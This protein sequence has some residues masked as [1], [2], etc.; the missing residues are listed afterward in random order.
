MQAQQSGRFI[1]CD[2]SMC[3]VDADR[4]GVDS[5]HRGNL[6]G[7]CSSV[8][9]MR[10]LFAVTL[11]CSVAA[12]AQAPQAPQAPQGRPR[13][14]AR[15]SMP[16]TAGAAAVEEKPGA[17]R[18]QVVSSTGEPLRKAEVSLRPSGGRGA[19]GGDP[20]M[21]PPG[22]GG[23]GSVQTTDASG[24]FAFEAVQP[25]TYTLSAQR[26]GFVRADYSRGASGRAPT[27]VEVTSGGAT[28]GI[29]IRMTPQAVLAGKVT[30]EDGDPIMH[31]SVQ[32]IRDRWVA[33][34]RTQMPMNSSNTDDRGEY[35][36]AGL[37]PG[38]YYVQVTSNRMGMQMPGQ[39][40]PQGVVGD[41]NYT[42]LLYPGVPEFSQAQP[43][44]LAPGQEM[45]GVDFRMRKSTTWR[46]RGQVLDDS[47]KPI[48]SGGVMA[49][50][51]DGGMSGP[52]AMGMA[53]G[54]EG[55]FEIAGLAPGTYTLMVSTSGRDELRMAG[56]QS[57]TVGNRDLEGV[58]LQMQRGFEISGLVRIDGTSPP[59]ASGSAR[60]MLEPMETGIMMGGG[61]SRE[62]N[63]QVKPDGAWALG[64]VSAGR[65]RITPTSLPEGTYLKAVMVGG[66]DITGG[67]QISAAAMGI[68]LVL[69]MKAPDVTGTVMNADKLPVTSGTVFMI[70]DTARRDRPSAYKSASLGEGG[71]FT[72]R[73]LAPGQYTIFA[74]PEVEDG[75]WYDPDFVRTLEG[76]GVAVK[77]AEGQS[78]T[79]QVPLS[80]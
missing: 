37:V 17:I 78:E 13:Q 64:N 57:V 35:R 40:R 8:L 34:R 51:V 4:L 61:G 65:Y 11:M 53:R 72:F 18:G 71:T 3:L 16:S 20:R 6:E 79:V 47:G 66:Q 9:S 22:M 77:L 60:V 29:A 75:S 15:S 2:F 67:A 28:G 30:D 19:G 68:E 62:A 70:P 7:F 52:R 49:V 80:L 44:V 14:T 42:P 43:L 55:K 21:G 59:A 27:P 39:A 54:P 73:G 25:G 76:K 63:G 33:G 5:V 31:A 36:I 58:V 50:P 38:K 32:I 26:A 1:Y 74:L 48:Q 45:R 12:W 23:G 56:R 46:V 69:G 24:N 10:F 41:L